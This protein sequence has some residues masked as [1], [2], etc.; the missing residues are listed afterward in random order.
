MCPEALVT[1]MCPEALVTLMCPEALVTLMCPEALVTLMCQTG[2]TLVCLCPPGAT[3]DTWSQDRAVAR[4]A[5][6]A[7]GRGGHGGRRWRGRSRGPHS[8]T[9]G[10]VRREALASVL[11]IENIVKSEVFVG[12]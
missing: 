4:G 12:L 2:V 1:V 9:H 10:Q 7:D 6:W 8:H 3:Q 5:Q 11:V